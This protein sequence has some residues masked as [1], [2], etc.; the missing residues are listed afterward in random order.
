MKNISLEHALLRAPIIMPRALEEL[1]SLGRDH[2]IVKVSINVII[3]EKQ[4]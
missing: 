1:F 3:N 4:T 2:A